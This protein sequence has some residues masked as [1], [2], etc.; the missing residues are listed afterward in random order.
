MKRWQL[1]IQ[2]EQD[3]YVG[4]LSLVFYTYAGLIYHKA[5]ISGKWIR[6][7]TDTGKHVVILTVHVTESHEIV[8]HIP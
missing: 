3:L 6:H 7:C 4:E 8:T 1:S 5:R 2:K